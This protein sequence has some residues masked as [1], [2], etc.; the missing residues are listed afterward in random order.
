VFPLTN[1]TFSA[2]GSSTLP[3]SFQWRFQGMD[4]PGANSSSYSLTNVQP[5]HAGD[6]TVVVSDTLGQSATWVAR[7][8]VL[9]HPVFTQEPTNRLAIV[10]TNATNITFT[11][12]ATSSTPITY[13]WRFGGT[14]LPAATANSL[15]I[16]NAQSKDVG[17][18]SVVATDS[19]GSITS[20]NATLTLLYLPFIIQ[21]PPSQIVALGG[22]ASFTI[23]ASGTLPLS[24]RW[25]FNNVNL[26]NLITNANTC[27]FTTNNVTTDG[28]FNVAITNTVGAA[29]AVSSNGFL[30]VLS[31]PTNQTVE[32][33]ADV[34]FSAAFMGPL[35]A[36][37]ARYQWQFNGVNLADA[38]NASLTL[39]HVTETAQGNYS[40]IVTVTTNGFS[41]PPATFSANLQ[42]R[43]QPPTL[44]NPQAMPDGTFQAVLQG[45]LNHSYILE[46][47]PNLTNWTTLDTIT[48]TNASTPFTDATATNAPQRFYRA[49]ASP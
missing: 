31:P 22:S 47:S 10:R 39:P 16:S 28:F 12:A 26:T 48:A 45:Q 44:A 11:A 14:D 17:D 40:L 9:T 38:T 5:A 34:T 43:V 33:G 24:F 49:R 1:V 30:Y 8:N 23:T 18:Y 29:L 15:V 35:N 2:V 3:I 25:R 7:L 42:V 37:T 13:Q 6:Y 4:I 27:I 19:Y 32:T 21:H 46:I 41:V 36:A 20:S